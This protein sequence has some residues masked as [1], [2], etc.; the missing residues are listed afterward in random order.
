MSDPGPTGQR[1]EQLDAITALAGAASQSSGSHWRAPRRTPILSQYAAHVSEERKILLHKYLTMTSGFDLSQKQWRSPQ[2]SQKI[3]TRTTELMLTPKRSDA[4]RWEFL[5][6]FVSRRLFGPQRG[7]NRSPHF[8]NTTTRC[9]RP[10]RGRSTCHFCSSSS[11]TNRRQEL[12]QPVSKWT[13]EV[14]LD[15]VNGRRCDTLQVPLLPK[16][17]VV[18]G[19]KHRALSCVEQDGVQPMPKDR[20]AEQGDGDGPLECSLAVGVAAAEAQVCVAV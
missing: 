6:K 15:S 5:R 11:L 2:I 8:S 3:A 4:S 16:H 20:G 7:R 14:F 12:R 17:A 19:W 9:W 13:K 18:A 1:Q 10:G